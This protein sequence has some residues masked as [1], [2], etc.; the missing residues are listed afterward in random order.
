MFLVH[1]G[2]KDI[3]FFVNNNLQ[4]FNKIDSQFCM[5]QV[6]KA[7]NS[8]STAGFEPVSSD[9]ELEGV[10]TTAASYATLIVLET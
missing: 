3:L 4:V 7:E 9:C 6:L 1:Q 10:G 8:L 5:K 2:G